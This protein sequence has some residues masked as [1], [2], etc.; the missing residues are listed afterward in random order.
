VLRLNKIVI[1]LEER[2]DRRYEMNR[3]LH[4]VGWDANYFSA[5]KPTSLDGFPSLG[6]K[7]CFLS[8]IEVLKRSI[9]DDCHLIIME[10]DLNFSPDFLVRWPNA[11]SEL[12]TRDWSIFYPAAVTQGAGG[13]S[14][15]EPSLGI[16][17]AHFM[18]INRESI[19]TI[20]NGLQ[21]ILARPAGHPD[22]GAM[23][24]DGAY[25]TIRAQD[26]KLRTYIYSPPLGY[27][28]SSRSDI[29][30][31]RFFDR[32]AALQKPIQMLR[33]LKTWIRFRGDSR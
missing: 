3:Q 22:G 24:V 29:A 27:Q 20:A 11:V 15:I 30:D 31:P 10:D 14:L 9:A 28:R 33:K 7:G 26:P 16:Q 17:T 25:S 32:S 12:L 23:H 13:L 6:A 8:H 21:A 19:A 4:R 5:V 18:L 2:F 1:N